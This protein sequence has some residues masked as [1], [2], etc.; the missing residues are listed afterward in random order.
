MVTPE[1]ESAVPLA[2]LVA[3]SPHLTAFLH[4]YFKRPEDLQTAPQVLARIENENAELMAQRT[5]VQESLAAFAVEVA[6]GCGDALTTFSQ[7]S[8]RVSAAA[9]RA[10]SASALMGPLVEELAT[11]AA[12]VARVER[13]RVYVEKMLEIEGHIGSADEALLFL[14]V[15]FSF[16]SR[17]LPS[18][19]ACFLNLDCHPHSEGGQFCSGRGV[20]CLSLPVR[21]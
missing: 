12:E 19:K 11:L 10:D 8:E 21:L 6:H 2:T 5:A 14:K 15:C 1:M 17:P 13:V 7:L 18:L 4:S 20:S 16:P 9:D 3:Q